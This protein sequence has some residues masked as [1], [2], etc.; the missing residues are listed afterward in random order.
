MTMENNIKFYNL[1][2]PDY[3]NPF[4]DVCLSADKVLESQN[5]CLSI[6]VTRSENR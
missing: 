2:N 4:Q 5:I 6:T 1:P 3:T